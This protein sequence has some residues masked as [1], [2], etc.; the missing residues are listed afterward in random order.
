[1]KQLVSALLICCLAASFCVG[2]IAFVNDGDVKICALNVCSMET[3]VSV[4]T[5]PATIPEP[6]YEPTPL[7]YVA[8]AF[9][10]GIQVMPSAVST[11]IEKP[12]TA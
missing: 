5:V 10:T 11:S 6:A 7:Q 1:M 4:D 2:H 8:A 3:G 12:P 9:T